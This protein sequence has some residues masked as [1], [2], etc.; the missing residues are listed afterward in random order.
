MQNF[1]DRTTAENHP[2]SKILENWILFLTSIF[3]EPSCMSNV[4]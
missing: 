4:E 3:L 1:V 2:P